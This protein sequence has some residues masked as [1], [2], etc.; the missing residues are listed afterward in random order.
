[1]TTPVRILLLEDSIQDAELIQ[2]LLEADHF[3]CE[4]TRVQTRAEFL[5]ALEHGR[6][7]DPAAT[8]RIFQAF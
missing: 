4:V 7:L 8:D 3:V 2:E 6:G 1:M 5:A